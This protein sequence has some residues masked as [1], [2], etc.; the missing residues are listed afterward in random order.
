MPRT[1]T[2]E[3]ARPFVSRVTRPK[4]VL[5]MAVAAT[6]ACTALAAAGGTRASVADEADPMAPVQVQPDPFAD[7]APV[8]VAPETSADPVGRVDYDAAAD[9]VEVHV[10]EADLVDVLRMLAAQSQRNIIAT[11]EVGGTVTCNLYDVT[12][13]QALDAILHSNGLAAREEGDF[14]YVYTQEQL[15]ELDEAN[16]RP[17]TRVFRLYHTSPTMAARMIEPAL[18]EGAVISFSDEPEAGVASDLSN[19]GGFGYAAGDMIVVR[20]FAE[21][22]DEVERVIDEL[23]ARPE[24]ILVEATILST[25]LNETNRLGVDLNLVGGV[26]LNQVVFG[27]AGRPLGGGVTPNPQDLDGEVYGGGTGAN[28][29]N[30]TDGLKVGFVSGDVSVFVSA[31]EGTTDTT[32]LANPKVLALNKQKGE[33]LV[34]RKDGYLTTSITET[35]ATQQVEFLET[36][37]K[38]IFRPYISRDGYIR[39]E[40]HPEDSSGG[41]DDRGLPSKVTT[42]VTTN[43]LV[44]DGRTVVIGGLFRE[45]ANVGRS[46]VPFL[47]N[48]PI[49]GAAFRKQTDSTLREEIIILLTPHVV[50]DLDRYSEL[51]ADELERAEKLRVG[52]REG[53]MPWGRERMAQANFDKALA[54]LAQTPP[55][56][57]RARFHLNAALHL[58]PA[59]I[60]AIELKERVTG[61]ELAESDQSSIR[62]FLRRAVH[63]D[64][65]ATDPEG[66]QDVPEPEVEAPATRP[67]ILVEADTAPVD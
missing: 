55:N 35:S 26:D 64:L 40:V 5:A 24:Q 19:G 38:L 60:E 13:Q 4:A 23:D 62:S 45:T 43:V 66:M 67:E 63:A 54:A 52:T 53:M 57:S 61:D 12:V 48:L 46:Q 37:T 42:E 39:L 32:V 31:L 8:P 44:K 50:K 14:I 18:S 29:A 34:G 65:K 17:E 2:P 25:T 58:N 27:G 15:D 1:V 20:D 22:L 7:T 51:S 36:G 28:F 6:M 16:R 41:V 21:H 11:R 47:G 3:F 33:V 56:R 30:N 9:T 59:F 10:S 49:V